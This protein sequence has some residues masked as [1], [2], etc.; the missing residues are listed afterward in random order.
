MSHQ[1]D[2]LFAVSLLASAAACAT[3]RDPNDVVDTNPPA[4][5]AE[6]RTEGLLDDALKT[7]PG[8][9]GPSRAIH[10]REQ[11]GRK[12]SMPASNSDKTTAPPILAVPW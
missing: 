4:R 1:R 2:D 10:R 11:T 8:W 9:P 3:A 5:Y 7:A 6:L 12:S